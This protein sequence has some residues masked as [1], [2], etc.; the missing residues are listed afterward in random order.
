MAHQ[1][2]DRRALDML[3][4]GRLR[5]PDEVGV[6]GGENLVQDQDVGGLEKRSREGESEPACRN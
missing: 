5:L 2:H 6:A 3:H 1:D 4:H